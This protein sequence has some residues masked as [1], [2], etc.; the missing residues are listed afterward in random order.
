[1]GNAGAWWGSV[2]NVLGEGENQLHYDYLHYVKKK[3][4]IFP[5]HLLFIFYILEVFL[6]KT[7]LNLAHIMSM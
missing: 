1:M 4:I 2:H 7:G 6:M 5:S 3:A